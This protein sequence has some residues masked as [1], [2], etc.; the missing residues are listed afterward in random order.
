MII[1]GLELFCPTVCYVVRDIDVNVDLDNEFFTA[2]SLEK[3][4]N[5]SSSTTSL[6]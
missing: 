6:S 3:V 1:L 4:C 2:G 5:L